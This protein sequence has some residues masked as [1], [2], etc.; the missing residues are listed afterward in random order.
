MR[1]NVGNI[2]GKKHWSVSQNTVNYFKTVMRNQKGGNIIFPFD[3]C[4][5]TWERSA[6][7][8]KVHKSTETEEKGCRLFIISFTCVSEI[9]LWAQHFII[10]EDSKMT[11]CSTVS[12]GCSGGF[13]F[14]TLTWKR[15]TYM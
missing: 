5:S 3:L 1:N 6:K 13:S 15:K 2:Q 11:K 14:C 10:A 4:I 9:P 8:K 12:Q 7:L